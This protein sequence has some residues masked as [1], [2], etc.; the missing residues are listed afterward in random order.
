MRGEHQPPANRSGAPRTRHLHVLIL[1]A[2]AVWLA[3]GCG[4]SGVTTSAATSAQPTAAPKPTAQPTT[5]PK[6]T[7]TPEPEGPTLLRKGVEVRKV[8]GVDPGGIALARNPVSGDIYM[9]HPDKGLFLVT[10]KAPGKLTKIVN[11]A[12]LIPDYTIS[13]M[14]FGPD[15]TLYAVANHKVGEKQ[16]QAIIRKCTVTVSGS[17]KCQTVATTEP[18]QLSNTYYDHMFNGIIVSPDNKWIYINSGSRTDHGEVEDNDAAYPD[19][20]DVPLTAKIFR[21][22]ASSVDLTLPN[23]DAK[24]QQAG[25]IYARGTRNA[26]DLEF[27]PNGDLFAIDNGPDADF[28]DELNWIREGKHYGFPW[29]FGSFDN[30]QQFPGYDASSDKHLSKDFSAVANG[31]YHDDPTF[32]KPP[33][34][35]TEPVTNLG[36]AAAQYRA[37][38]GSQR[39]AIKDAGMLKSFTPH[40]SPLGLQFATDAKLPA[41]LRG[42][43]K[44]LSAFLLSFGSAGGTLTDNGKD[45]LHLKLTKRGE[46]YESVTNQ[47]ATGFKFPIAAVLIENRLYVLEFGEKGAIWELTFN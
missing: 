33:G 25:Y 14:T 46:N 34:E 4:N 6:P 15:G 24:L 3:T 35:L 26:F 39:D 8:V 47:I 36:P 12:D 28:P 31:K 21:L 27:A 45:L 19:V 22:P 7:A 1:C 11:A 17:A 32:P 37:D 40:R 43:D 20:R 42:D 9:L 29:R 13:G 16:N 30:P 18:Y 41:D 38:D 5:P 10:L 23:D 44:A 2:L